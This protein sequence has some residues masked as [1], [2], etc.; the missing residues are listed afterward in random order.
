MAPLVIT[1]VEATQSTQIFQSS[2]PLCG[3]QPCPDNSIPLVVN[4]RTIL[5]VYLSGGIPGNFIGATVF[6]DPNAGPP[7]LSQFQVGTPIRAGTQPPQRVSASD[8][9][10]IDMLVSSSG[11]WSFR[12]LAVEY[13]P[14]WQWQRSSAPFSINLSFHE[15]RRVRIRLVRIRYRNA[16]RNLD[17][18]APTVQEFWTALDFVQSVLPVPMPG[19]EIVHESEE[20][21]DGDFTRIDPSAHDSTWPGFAGN[22]GTTGNLLNIMDRLVAA[23]SLPD[24]VIYVGIYPAAARQSAFAGWAVSR[25]IITDR[26]PETLAHELAHKLCVPQH[27]PCGTPANV[28]GSYPTYGMFP[29]GSIGEVGF[30]PRL[31]MTYDPVTVRDLMT[32]CSPRWISPYNYRKVFD[33]LT[34]LPPPPEPRPGLIDKSVHVLLVRFPDR[35]TRVELPLVPRRPPLP[36]PIGETPTRVVLHDADRR[37]LAT[38]PANLHPSS[39]EGDLQELDWLVAE[40]P[41]LPTAVSLDVMIDGKTVF[42]E[43]LSGTTPV[44]EVKWP[45]ADELRDG[46]GELTWTAKE[47]VDYIVVRTTCDGGESWIAYVL[48]GEKQSLDLRTGLLRPGLKCAIEVLALRGYNSARAVSESFTV[49]RRRTALLIVSPSNGRVLSRGDRLRL[50]AISYAPNAQITW[51]SDLDGKLGEGAFILAPLLQPGRHVIEARSDQPFETPTEVTVMV[52]D[53]P[54]PAAP[55]H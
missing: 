35:W 47:R 53:T 1:A 14:Q 36:T 19:F 6:H 44:L 41:V 15:R 54:A 45:S 3:G 23:E 48:P 18:A 27:A 17:L 42:R 46:R 7:D 2:F 9:V 8:T 29:N 24:D 5:R 20:L 21:Y 32:Y 25:W 10:Q 55:M 38:V 12:V 13:D 16:A 11:T 39:L 30:D 51:F 50:E 31:L 22:N 52:I 33:C 26:A 28:D 37:V 49:V 43:K 40:V 4:R 34:P